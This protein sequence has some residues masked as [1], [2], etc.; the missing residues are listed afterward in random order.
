MLKQHEKASLNQKGLIRALNLQQ[1]LQQ[2]GAFMVLLR[3]CYDFAIAISLY[4]TIINVFSTIRYKPE[5]S[6]SNPLLQK[7][8]F[9]TQSQL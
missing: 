3:R 6:I 7:S 1:N 5:V 8:S 4:L 2:A 9:F